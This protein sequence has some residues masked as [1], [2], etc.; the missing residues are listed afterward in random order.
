MEIFKLQCI[1]NNDVAN[2]SFWMQLQCPKVQVNNQT[3][4]VVAIGQHQWIRGVKSCYSSK[5]IMWKYDKIM[6]TTY[7]HERNVAPMGVEP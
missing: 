5:I 7:K 3:K 2:Y 6:K 1:G 4:F